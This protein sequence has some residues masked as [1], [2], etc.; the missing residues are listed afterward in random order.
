MRRFLSL[1]LLTLAA[2]A[3][4]AD[5]FFFQKGDRVVFLGDS[6]TIL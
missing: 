3:A 5:P 6:I 2:P 1:I 4:A